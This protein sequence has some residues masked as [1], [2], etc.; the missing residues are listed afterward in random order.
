MEKRTEVPAPSETLV[1]LSIEKNGAGIDPPDLEPVVTIMADGTVIIH[2]EGGDKEAAHAF[3]QSLELEGK[4]LHR[5][6]ELSEAKYR[7]THELGMSVVAQLRKHGA[8]TLANLFEGKLI[9]IKNTSAPTLQ[10][11]AD[12]EAAALQEVEKNNTSQTAK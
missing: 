12:S 8:D 4:T 3:Y 1:T 9:K 6:L 11:I 5:W 2:K 10:E 7:A